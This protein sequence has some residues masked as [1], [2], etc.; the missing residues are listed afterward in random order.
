MT[1]TSTS[2][3][4]RVEGARRTG[5]LWGGLDGDDARAGQWVGDVDAGGAAGLAETE[6]VGALTA[7][8]AWAG[9]AATS[10]TAAVRPTMAMA[11]STRGVRFMIGCPFRLCGVPV[12]A[13]GDDRMRLGRPSTD[14]PPL[15]NSEGHSIE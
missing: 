6:D 2:V 14:E 8:P 12:G 1:A 15:L 5:A 11:R 7:R 9:I 3:R 13:P 10:G 4:G